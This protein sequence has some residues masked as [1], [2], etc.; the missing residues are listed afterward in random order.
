L[1]SPHHGKRFGERSGEKGVTAQ[2]GLRKEKPVEGFQ[3]IEGMGM[4]T[5][6]LNK[7]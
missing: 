5:P 7:E 2:G 4:R 6:T 3:E 1:S